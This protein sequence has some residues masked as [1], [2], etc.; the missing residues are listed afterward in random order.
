MKI[1]LIPLE[2][3]DI[4]DCSSILEF[5]NWKDYKGYFTPI[6]KAKEVIFMEFQGYAYIDIEGTWMKCKIPLNLLK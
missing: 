4:M 5:K 3:F 6:K 2:N 1:K